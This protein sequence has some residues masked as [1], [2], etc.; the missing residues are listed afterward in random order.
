MTEGDWERAGL[1]SDAIKA[2]TTLPNS[3]ELSDKEKFEKARDLAN[4]GRGAIDM[5]LTKSSSGQDQ[6]TIHPP[7]SKQANRL[8]KTLKRD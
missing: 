7:G 6:Q 5:I 3:D 2:V 4:L 1:M 8:W